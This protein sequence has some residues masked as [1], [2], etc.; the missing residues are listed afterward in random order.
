V[1]G[2][3][4]VDNLPM[5]VPRNAPGVNRLLDRCAPTMRP[6]EQRFQRNP[7]TLSPERRCARPCDAHVVLNAL[8]AG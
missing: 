2:I 1:I 7:R 6:P 8:A 3:R 4:R 5:I